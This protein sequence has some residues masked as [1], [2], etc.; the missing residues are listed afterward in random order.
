MSPDYQHVS[1]ELPPEV[2]EL[3]RSNDELRAG[4]RLAANEIRR[5]RGDRRVDSPVLRTF[6]KVTVTARKAVAAARTA[7]RPN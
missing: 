6:R 1:S 5:L 3:I 2:E 7:E 4:I